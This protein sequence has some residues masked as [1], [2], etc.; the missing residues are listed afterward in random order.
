MNFTPPKPLE[1]SK[2]EIGNRF[3]VQHP[4][5]VVPPNFKGNSFF[6]FRKTSN[7]LNVCGLSRNFVREVDQEEGVINPDALV[8]PVL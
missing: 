7:E 5:W 4:D 6:I 1:F 3:I 8:T 2:L